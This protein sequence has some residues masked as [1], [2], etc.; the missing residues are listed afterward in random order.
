[1]KPDWSGVQELATTSAGSGWKLAVK[2]AALPAS[3]PQLRPVS[4]PRT[5]GFFQSSKGVVLSGD[6]TKGVVAY[7]GA[8]PG[9]KQ[10][11]TTRIAVCDLEKGN[12]LS[13]AGQ[14]G[15]YAPLAIRDDG[16]Q[17]LMRT[18]VF[19]PDGHG[20]L[21]FWNVT[22]RDSARAIEWIHTEGAGG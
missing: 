20:T 22:R 11:G 14:S 4:I 21:E 13:T 6:G 3:A 2:S 17:I 12:L 16:M 5:T 19:G 9:Q 7:A 18:D 1:M 10:S 8:Q 15:L